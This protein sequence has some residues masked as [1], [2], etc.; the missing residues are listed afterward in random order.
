M[1]THR[2]PTRAPKALHISSQAPG[3]TLHWTRQGHIEMRSVAQRRKPVRTMPSVQPARA[4][5][6]EHSPLLSTSFKH[7]FSGVPLRAKLTISRP[8][9]A[10][11]R[12]ADRLAEKVMRM[13][14]TGGEALISETA[15][16]ATLHRK[17]G[18]CTAGGTACSGCAADEEKRIQRSAEGDNALPN[19][20]T[21]AA[22]LT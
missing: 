18:A 7:D 3:K 16:P 4:P 2:F 13:P 10:Q 1:A 8:G 5:R 9:D 14:A 19:M 21:A 22:Q 20:T 12:E 11:E 17:C 15:K 6:A